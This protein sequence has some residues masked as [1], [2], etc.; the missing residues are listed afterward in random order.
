MDHKITR[1]CLKIVTKKKK[2]CWYNHN[3]KYKNNLPIGSLEYFGSSF[4]E[5]LKLNQVGSLNNNSF[6]RFAEE[7]MEN[8]LTKQ[9]SICNAIK[10]RKKF[11][12]NE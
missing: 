2:V 9:S 1:V 11:V 7:Y 6:K 8:R 4:H 3:S 12:G 5:N 10:Y